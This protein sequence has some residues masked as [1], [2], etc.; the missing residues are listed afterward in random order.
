[1]G[2]A[3]PGPG[4]CTATLP[5]ESLRYLGMN[6]RKKINIFVLANFMIS[7]HMVRILLADQVKCS[8]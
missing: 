5:E 3:I 7:A 8:V 6:Y 2:E 4:P 1:M